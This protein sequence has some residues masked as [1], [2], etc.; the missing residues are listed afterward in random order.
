MSEGILVPKQVMDY[1]DVGF[2]VCVWE[3]ERGVYLKNGEGDYFCVQGRVGD[4]R[5]EQR[6]IDAVKSNFD[7]KGRPVWFPSFRK[8]TTSEWEDQMERLLDGKVPDAVDA[9]LQADGVV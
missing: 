8:I 7:L 5:L 1:P 4:L 3:L 2:G 6:M 9:V